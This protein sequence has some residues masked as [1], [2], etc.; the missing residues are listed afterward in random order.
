MATLLLAGVGGAI[1]GA[2][3]GG[4]LGVSSVVIG[5]AIGATVGS[6]IDQRLFASGSAPVEVGR[7]DSLR[8]MGSREGTP[9]PRVW[10]RMR[11]SGQ[12]ISPSLVTT[13]RRSPSPSNANPRSACSAL[14]T[15]TRSSMFAGSAGSG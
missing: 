8:I 4:V 12:M 3:G 11:V 14:T 9:V 7:R 5:K 6:V 1:G 2:V 10:G 15:V 13:P